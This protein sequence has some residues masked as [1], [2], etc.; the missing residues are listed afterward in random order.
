VLTINNSDVN[1]N[2][3]GYSVGVLAQNG[4]KVEGDSTNVTTIG[5]GAS[6]I[7]VD[8]GGVVEWTGGSITTE[9]ANA[10][11]VRAHSGAQ[12]GAQAGTVNLDGTAVTTNGSNATALLA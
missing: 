8:R 9:G 12:E 5:K 2:G 11:A 4:G 6:G 1:A 3:T 7:E 10:A